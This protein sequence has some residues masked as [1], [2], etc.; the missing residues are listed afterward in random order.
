MAHDLSRGNIQRS[1]RLISAVRMFPFACVAWAFIVFLFSSTMNEMVFQRDPGL[2]DAYRCPLPN[3]Y[4]I[5]MIDVTDRG[6]V[7]NPRTQPAHGVGE[8]ADAARACVL[9][10][11]GSFILGGS[12]CRIDPGRRPDDP[13][14]AFHYF[15]LD[16]TSGTRTEIPTY[17]A[18]RM[19]AASRNIQLH[20]E[21][22]AQIYNRYRFTWFDT[23][24]TIAMFGVPAL[25]GAYLF[26]SL[27]RLRK[28]SAQ[29]PQ[30][31]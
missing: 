11:A 16:T 12:F 21:P 25:C 30:A 2:G 18:L 15:L 26:R 19:A 22:I 31:A 3:G 27:W 7:F 1:P 29:L 23:V 4:A 20:L 10:L 24:I 9:Q 28:G 8:T 14:P 17:E 13:D 6:I 5:L